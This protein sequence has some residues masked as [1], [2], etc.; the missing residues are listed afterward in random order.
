MK[1]PEQDLSQTEEWQ[2]P[3]CKA[4]NTNFL[5]GNFGKYRCP[6]CREVVS[7]QEVD[8]REVEWGGDD[9]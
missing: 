2:C 8:T 9:A 7:G 6:N 5:V 4:W 1:V 3:S